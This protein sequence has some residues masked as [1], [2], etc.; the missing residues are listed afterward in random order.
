MNQATD[1]DNS[2][3]ENV[4]KIVSQKDL[5]YFIKTWGCQMNEH[6]SEKIEGMLEH[7]GYM[8]APDEKHADI[9]VFNTCCVRENAELKVY[10]HIGA[11]KHLK[12]RNPDMIICVCGC[13][14]QQKQISEY[15]K[16]TYPFVDIVIGTHNTHIL[17]EL[18]QKV[19]KNQSPI[20]SVWDKE[21]GIVERMPVK[22]EKG[23][24]AWVTVMYGCDN[25]CTYCIVPYVRGRERSRRIEDITE[26]IKLLGQQGYKEIT[27]L[28]QNVNSYGKDLGG[29]VDFADLLYQVDKIEQ[30]ERIRFITSHPKDLS[31]RLIYAM[32]DCDKVCEQLHLPIQSGSSA[33]LKKMNR[34]YTKEQYLE[35][36]DKVR[37]EIPGVAISTDIIVGFPGETDQDFNETIDVIKRVKYDSAFTFI[38]SKRSG[39][40][41]AK[42]QNQ[43][44]EDT[45]HERL[46]RLIEVQTK[47]SQ[48]INQKLLGSTVEVLVEQVSKKNQHKV[49]GRTRTGKIVNFQ[50]EKDLIGKLIKVKITN[51]L[52]HWLEGNVVK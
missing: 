18:V 21:S 20:V 7:M 49:T 25:F 48:Q 24:K 2:L 47:I 8:P 41:A 37:K 50:G 26:E 46:Y 30:I 44:D 22:R 42:M 31:D 9:V 4:Y 15:I 23:V 6:D 52:A 36:V 35:L 13:M 16:K 10:G 5:K 28:G 38:Y 33:I 39:T 51:V 14:T 32:R 27:L 29:K 43:I 11:L 19:L 1:F 34:R 12:R 17:P 45:K 40:P 3:I